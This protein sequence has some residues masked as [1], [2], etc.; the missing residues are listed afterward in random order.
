MLLILYVFILC[1]LYNIDKVVQ[2]APNNRRISIE[3]HWLE[4]NIHTLTRSFVRSFA[5]S[6]AHTIPHTPLMHSAFPLG[7]STVATF[8]NSSMAHTSYSWADVE[9]ESTLYS[10]WKW[11]YMQAALH[12]SFVLL[13]FSDMFA[14]TIWFFMFNHTCQFNKFINWRKKNKQQIKLLARNFI[15]RVYQPNRKVFVYQ[16]ACFGS[17]EWNPQA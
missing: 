17:C 5:C 7:H 16:I 12:T 3:K 1:T 9:K 11:K 13:T 6:L 10:Y 14:N 15:L 2:L 8:G 4:V